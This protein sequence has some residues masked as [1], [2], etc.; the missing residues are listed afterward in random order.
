MKYVTLGADGPGEAAGVIDPTTC[1]A[2][3]NGAHQPD[4]P[5]RAEESEGSPRLLG[6]GP[7][8]RREGP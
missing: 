2:R 7:D 1:L 5:G 3:L 6:E 4:R 8:G